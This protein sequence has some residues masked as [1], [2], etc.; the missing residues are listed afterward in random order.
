MLDFGA[1][2][3]LGVIAATIAHQV[4]GF[5]WYGPILGKRW[6]VAMGLDPAQQR[7]APDA[8]PLIISMVCAL[9]MA[10]AMGL[11]L[12]L[13]AGVDTGV[14]IVV[15]LIIGVGFVGATAVTGHVFEGRSREVLIIGLG[16]QIL[17]IV[18]MGAIIG[19]LQATPMIR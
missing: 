11:I 18:I 8:K 2:S 5:L 19:T 13:V 10:I 3:W 14:G 4:L 6:M 12:T 9:V 15:G 17:G 7:M 16:Y 1:I